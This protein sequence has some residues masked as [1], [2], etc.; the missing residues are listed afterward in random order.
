MLTHIKFRK[1]FRRNS[2]KIFFRFYPDSI[3]FNQGQS[4][5]INVSLLCGY[6]SPHTIFL[7]LIR[8]YPDSGKLKANNGG[9]GGV[10]RGK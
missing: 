5:D 4:I 7:Y 2:Y 9:V 1:R 3:S 8:E 10:G 6:K